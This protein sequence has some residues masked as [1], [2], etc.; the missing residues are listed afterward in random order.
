M[1]PTEACAQRTKSELDL[2]LNEELK[3]AFPASD[4]PKILAFQAI[5]AKLRTSRGRAL[6]FQNRGPDSA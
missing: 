2:Q 1:A 5:L 4:P 3:G 6:L